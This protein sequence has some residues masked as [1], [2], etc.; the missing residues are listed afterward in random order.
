MR[1][2]T[3]KQELRE[4][5]QQTGLFMPPTITAQEAIYGYVNS[6]DG[7]GLGDF[8][9]E[10]RISMLKETDAQWNN[11]LVKH[12]KELGPLRILR[13]RYVLPKTKNEVAK[14]I[15][16]RRGLVLENS[17]ELSHFKASVKGSAWRSSAWTIPLEMLVMWEA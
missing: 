3:R 7:N 5:F 12:K 11:K 8:S 17:E 13:V 16:D 2:K 6:T 15:W 1:T 14:Q 9:P 4:F 10:E